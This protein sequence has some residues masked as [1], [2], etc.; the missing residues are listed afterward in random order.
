MS[1][2]G[3]SGRPTW[4]RHSSRKSSAT[5]SCQCVYYFFVCPNNGIRGC[6]RLG[7][8]TCTQ[9]L[10]HA[11]A[12]GGCADT[13][14]ESA[15]KVDS[16]GKIPETRTRVS[17]PPW[18]F[19]RTLY[20]L[21]NYRRHDEKITTVQMHDQQRSIQMTISHRGTHKTTLR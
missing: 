7:F 14:R 18:L 13:V 21:S 8:L 19:S 17:I 12:H 6:Q 1:L 4:V 5:H 15:L 9:M 20:Q 10:M 3:N 11:I 16:R 2:A